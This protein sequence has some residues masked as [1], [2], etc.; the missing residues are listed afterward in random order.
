MISYIAYYCQSYIEKNPKTHTIL[1]L[2]FQQET[3]N[4]LRPLKALD[5][6]LNAFYFNSPLHEIIPTDRKRQRPNLKI[7]ARMT[8][9]ALDFSRQDAKE[10]K[11]HTDTLVAHI[12][13]HWDSLLRALTEVKS[14][15]GYDEDQRT[16]DIIEI[17]EILK[18]KSFSDRIKD[19]HNDLAKE[20]KHAVIVLYLCLNNDRYT[21]FGSI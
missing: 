18:Q 9:D 13:C 6:C 1:A 11:D 5:T 12:Y 14:F 3:R 16:Q 7:W 19:S 17:C 21:H 10:F 15:E 4:P 8:V 2:P 20:G